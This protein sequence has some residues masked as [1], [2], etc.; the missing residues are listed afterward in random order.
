MSISLRLLPRRPFSAFS[1]RFLSSKKP[2]PSHSRPLTVS[3]GF[4][5]DATKFVTDIVNKVKHLDSKVIPPLSAGEVEQ[6][7]INAFL[8]GTVEEGFVEGDK[9]IKNYIARDDLRLDQV[10]SG[11]PDNRGS[12][13]VILGERG[14]GKSTAVRR[15]IYQQPH[16]KGIVYVECPEDVDDFPA[17]LATVL[18]F[19]PTTDLEGSLRRLTVEEEVQQSSSIRGRFPLYYTQGLRRHLVSAS[20]KYRDTYG[21]APVLII[22]SAERLAKKASLLLDDLQD[23]AKSMADK[24]GLIFVFVASDFSLLSQMKPRSAFSRAFTVEIG[25]VPDADAIKY[26]TGH[27]IPQKEAEDVVRHI[28]GGVFSE[29]ESYIKTRKHSRFTYASYLDA[30]DAELEATFQS[31]GVNPDQEVFRDLLTGPL[32]VSKCRTALGS[33]VEDLLKRDIL[34]AHVN[35]TYSFHNRHIQH[36]FSRKFPQPSLSS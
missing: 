27:D 7:I 12:Y 5:P 36:W 20:I 19:R 4:V 23:L 21:V 22:D 9:L 18:K 8:H 31:I 24:H 10:L 11:H 2:E 14:T 16:P 26:L 15:T 6:D 33:V 30:R 28:T 32:T 17:T 34:A 13:L 35:H 25:P 29:M 1:P 3:K